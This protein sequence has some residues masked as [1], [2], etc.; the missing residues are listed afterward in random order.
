MVKLHYYQKYCFFNIYFNYETTQYLPICNDYILE[1]CY[2]KNIN[3]FL[4]VIIYDL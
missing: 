4:I 1:T 2:G 3:D